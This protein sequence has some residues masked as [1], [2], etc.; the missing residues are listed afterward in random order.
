VQDPASYTDAFERE[1]GC[2]VDE[3]RM[4]LPGAVG[5]A[6]LVFDGIHSARVRIG[7]GSLQLRWQALAPRQIA[8]VRIA[9]L[10]V[11]YRFDHI[12]DAERARFMRRFDLFM[13]RG[14]G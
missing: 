2:T 8:L 10:L 14:G 12:A 11:S 6:P 13:Q 5:D 3:W 9:R 1:H 7:D 4:W